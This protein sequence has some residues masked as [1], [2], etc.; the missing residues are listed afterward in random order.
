MRESAKEKCQIPFLDPILKPFIPHPERRRHLIDLGLIYADILIYSGLN[1]FLRSLHSAFQNH[2]QPERYRK[3]IQSNEPD[4]QQLEHFTALSRT[5][6]YRP[7]ISII[8]PVWETNESWLRF[9]IESVLNQTYENWELCLVDGGS[10]KGYIRSLLEEYARADFRIKVKFLPENKGIALNSNEAL[11][12]ATGD[13]VGFLDHDDEL[14]PFALHEVVKILNTEK[15]VQLLYSDEDK[16]DTNGKRRDPFF[17]PDWSPDLFLSQNYICHF[18]VIK[19]TVLDS[20]GGFRQGYEGSQDYDLFLR[21][22]E[23]I[24]AAGISHIPKILYHWRTTQESVASTSLVKP[25]ATVSAKHALEDA[26]TRRGF[27]VQVID[28]LYPT[29]YRVRYAVKGTPH[30][31]IVIP[32]KDHLEVLRHCI[33]SI[34]EKTEYPNYEIII[35]DNQSEEHETLKYYISLQEQSKIK[36]L[37]YN[38]PFNFSSINNYGVTHSDSP[39][40][41]FL[42]NDTEVI[43]GEWLSAMLEHAQH[44][45]VGA[46]GAKL[47]YP[48][49]LIQ[50]AG[51]VLGIHGDFVQMDIAGHSHKFVSNR[52]PGYFFRPH[53]IGNYSA[54]TAACLMIRKDVFLEV[55]GFEEDLAVAYNDVDLCLKIREKGYRIVYTPYAVLHHHESYSRG[56]EKSPEKQARFYQD[57]LWVRTRWGAI[58]DSGDPY[59]NPNLTLKKEDFSIKI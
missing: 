2:F 7:R 35:I 52:L 37:H 50:H 44:T 34:L 14:A 21:C 3:W 13:F 1:A 48:N 51:I 12:L 47:L 11:S 5:F 4:P 31:S 41:L 45:G 6:S 24:P 20:M 53:I 23:K 57:T 33:N 40:I 46:V 10:T 9:A 30:V 18:C 43:S 42:N 25:Y 36:I 28:G 8:T 15:N 56:P 32:T 19:K 39:Y 54:V 22:T 59:Y 49:D 29:T 55:G 27:S 16:I 58:I 17:K 26:A 38:E